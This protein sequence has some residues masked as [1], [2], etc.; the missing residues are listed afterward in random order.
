VWFHD[1][2]WPDGR[3]YRIDEVELIRKVVLAHGMP[4]A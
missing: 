1:I 3:P 2:L 4:R